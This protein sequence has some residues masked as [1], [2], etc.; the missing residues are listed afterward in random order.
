MDIAPAP[1]P[2]AHADARQREASDPAVSAFVSASAGSG[3]TKLLTDRLLRLMLGGA[4]PARIQCLT[5]TRA[6]AAE[7]AMR[8]Q[9]VL[10][11]WVMLEDPALT[12][13]LAAL[14]VAAD[15]DTLRRAR[16]LFARVLDLP[17]GMRIG[18]IH[19][20]CQS[21]LRRFPLEAQL[22]PHF[23]LLEDRDADLAR[24][25]AVEAL[26]GDLPP[27]PEGA[28][29]R[30]ASVDIKRAAVAKV[31]AAS[32]L[33][34][35]DDAACALI[36]A[37]ER[38]VPLL[39]A[40][41]DSI[42]RAVRQALRVNAEAGGIEAAVIWPE[43]RLVREA[44]HVMVAQ[45]SDAIRRDAFDQL[46]WL[47]QTPGDRARSWPEWRG[48]FFNKDGKPCAET[49]LVNK[50]LAGRRPDVLD[51]MR[52]EQHRIGAV[53]EAIRARDLADHTL[54]LL[55]LALPVARQYAEEKDGKLRL[56][57]ADLID[58]T[59][60]LLRDP[61]AGWVLYKLDGGLD[62]ILLDEV[63]DTAP[64]QWEIAGALADEFFA[65]EGARDTDRTIFAV[66]DR[67]QSIFSFQ[68]AEPAAFDA[69]RDRLRT[70]IGTAGR[71][72]RDVALDVSFRSA[73]P[74]L[75]LVDE[76][77]RDPAL[78]PGVE[79]TR[80]ISNRPGQAGC[81]ELWP[82]APESG[83][84]DPPEWS[85]PAEP[86][87]T[88]SARQKLAEAVAAYI[89]ESLRTGLAL[90]SRARALAPGDVL[91]LV[92]RRNDFSHALVRCLKQRGV[93]VAGLDRMVL[94]E[95]PAV[96]D[97][98]TLCDVLLLPRDDLSLACVMTSPLGGLSDA[99]L[100]ELAPRRAGSLW[101]ALRARAAEKPGWQALAD[102]IVRLLARVDYVT[103]HALLSE[104]LGAEGG[105][106]RLLARLGPEAAEPIDELLAAAL[107]YARAGP[108][109][110]QGFLHWLRGSGA[111]V[112]R[113]AQAE[114][115]GVVRIMTVHGAKGLQAPLVILPDTTA[116]PAA[117]ETLL[118]AEADGLS[119]PVWC[120]VA[121]M[122]CE[123]AE[124]LRGAV[125]Q[126]RA[127][128]HN[129]LLYVALTRA[130]DRLVICGATPGR[131]K[132]PETSW[133]A[134]AEKAI[135]R[136]RTASAPFGQW[137]TLLRLESAQTAAPDRVRAADAAVCPTDLPDWAGTA[138][139][140]QARPPAPEPAVPSRL[141]PSR[142]EHADLGPAPPSA[143]PLVA[144]GG[145]ESGR[146]RRG[147]LLHTL[148]QHLP[149]LP[150][151]ER[152]AATRRFLAREPA[153]PDEAARA[154]TLAEIMT[155]L[156]HP[157][158]APLFG[159]SSRA[160]VPL[161][162]LVDGIVVGGM[163]DRIAILPDRVLVA[164]YKTN[165]RPPADTADV[166]VLYLRQMAAYRTV[167][168]RAYPGRE[169][170]CA[171]VWT[172]GG[173]V[174]ELAPNLLDSHAPAWPGVDPTPQPAHLSR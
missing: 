56:D 6:A 98:L 142:P 17:G 79:A 58:R 36:E 38:L 61:G 132:I 35:F 130:E 137:G 146:F 161:T 15:A 124:R 33:Q 45:G 1:D 78:T 86:V 127:E 11:Q 160:E 46:D 99:D 153:L 121:E 110:L 22:S 30:A 82:L 77:F 71:A 115:A 151:A 12:A 107:A 13:R 65:G 43:E 67:K 19:A 29:Q 172:V 96:A 94:T 64:A 111:E 41:F 144:T 42:E 49:S 89:D 84:E 118:W 53:E 122:R 9:S 162:G 54:A 167:L 83:T 52:A 139:V 128:E 23:G 123:A 50:G 145:P 100:I 155:V 16:A 114:S 113:E 166:P 97:L 72:F 80:H 4:D 34:R 141:A 117:D 164:D 125:S 57:Y 131:G 102:L 148:L 44:L 51:A 143:S 109:S 152:E 27:G 40:P 103:P 126:R 150:A 90:P 135:R 59:A 3:K 136:L 10:G 18:T 74:I 170:R 2:R 28:P 7:M 158:L 168:R 47:A 106:A 70:Q 93:P 81:V 134:L 76:V 24:A 147:Y 73:P 85:A 140:W 88:K 25:A 174:M 62:H 32:T 91:V 92:R 87:R 20:F 55:A 112:K 116:L 101:E 14:D 163:V 31:A 149:D 138:P 68:G 173:T 48:H 133:Y 69:W 63:Q 5:Y 26:L 108:P 105:R 169:V 60:A 95:Q 129:R 165:A 154:A 75:T 104:I 21:L 120:P 37:R 39:A 159:P 156:N 8:L 66:G 157:S 119:V 171:L